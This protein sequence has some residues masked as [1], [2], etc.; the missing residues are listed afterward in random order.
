[1]VADPGEV[2]RAFSLFA[3]PDNGCE[4]I[5]LRS[6]FTR[7]LP[8]KDVDGLVREVENLPAGIGVY[9]RLN[10]VPVTLTRAANNV[11]IISRRWL[12]IDIDPVKP[13]KFKDDSASDAEKSAAMSVCDSVYEL[14]SEHDWP[15]P[16]I[17]DSGNGFSLY[18]RCNFGTDQIVTAHYR[19]LLVGLDKQFA[20]SP[21]KIDK[22][23]HNLGRL[24]KI[25]GTWARKGKVIDGRPHRSSKLLIVPSVIESV[26]YD[27]LRETAY[28]IDGPD[29]IPQ[30][31]TAY[32]PSNGRV[33]FGRNWPEFYVGKAVEKSVAKIMLAAV[34]ERNNILNKEAYSLAGLINTGLLSRDMIEDRLA[35]AARMAGLDAAEIKATIRSGINK[36]IGKPRF[37]PDPRPSN[38]AKPTFESPETQTPPPDESEVDDPPPTGQTPPLTINMAKVKP[39]KVEWLI[40]NR[41]PKRFLTVFAGRTAVGKSFVAHDLIARL[42]TGSEIPD[43]RGLCFDPGGALIIGEDS[44]EYVLAPRLI[45]AGADMTRI[46]TMTWDAMA[47]YSLS[48]IGMLDQACSEVP[49]GV[50]LIMIDPPTNFL[51]NINENRNDD[52]RQLIMNVVAWCFTK[53]LAF[54]FV[55]HTNKAGGKGLEALAR[56]MGSVAWTTTARIAHSFTMDPDDASR[57]LWVPM[58]SNIGPVVKGLAYRI[59]KEDPV[60]IDW[61]GEVDTTSDEAFNGEKRNRADV[62]T[63]WLLDRF[64]ERLEWTSDELFSR[65]E[66]EGISRNAIFAARKVLNPPRA[67]K[68]VQESGKDEYVWWVP[69]DW[70]PLRDEKTGQ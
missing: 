32:V 33:Y 68:R 64:R 18:Y 51:K 44:A 53:D 13:E 22:G 4:V 55:L 35:E 17:A 60:I 58:K 69:G 45:A 49:G 28:D 20:D 19:K 67:K 63:D 41:I 15:P 27:L 9:F 50:S 47:K 3:D 65:G 1:M 54:I 21:G 14:L 25:P 36:G 40:P 11:D 59:T 70:P 16:V 42:T 2:R 46:N 62:A 23:V 8:G 34:G 24:T 5:A 37:I 31:R 56:V 29:P 43:G 12:Y 57:C 48:D 6:G 52:V 10:P 39:L 66:K 26:D 30:T 61:L 7:V 38:D